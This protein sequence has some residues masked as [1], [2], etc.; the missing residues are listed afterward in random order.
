[1]RVEEF[2]RPKNDNRRGIHW[3][4]SV[5]HPAGSALDFWIS[6]LL[7][8]NVKWVKLLDDG[9][10]SSLDLCRR[11]LV[12][13][14]MPI[15]RLYRLEPNPGHIGGRE[16]ETVR[17]LIAE[18][19]RYFEANNE[20]DLP[21]EWKGGR[22]PPD[23]LETVI[24]NF[25]V[26]ADKIIGLGGLPAFPAM[27]V[28][29]TD[30]AME[31]VVQ[32]GRADLFSNG[33]WVALHNY[34]LNHPL[35]YP[36]DPVNQEGA[37]ATREEY[38]RLGPWAWE[39]RSLEQINA[40]RAA[41]KHPGATLQDD[42][43]CFLAFHLLDELIVKTLGHKVPIL[44]TEGG[45]V[46]GW[47]DDRRYPRID[48]Y[49]HAA[50]AVAINDFM[51]GGRAIHG[52]R[53]PDN[54]FTACHWLLANYRL[55]FMAPGW[56][57]NSWYSDWWN[58]DFHLKGE[59]PAVAAVKAMPNRPVDLA[60]Q[61]V[62][63]GRVLR[64]DND[65]SLPGLTVKL[66]AAGQEV[67]STGTASGGMFR[68]AKL[69]PGAYDLAIAPWGEVRQAVIAA[70]E[71]VQPVTIRLTGGRS[72]V[73]VGT[74]RN[75]AGIPLADAH[76]TLQRHGVLIGGTDTGEDGAFSFG[77]LPSGAYRL[78]APGI[79]VDGITLD[80]WQPKQLTLI[81]SEVDSRLGPAGGFAQ[82][83]GSMPGGRP[84]RVVR[85]TGAAGTRESKLA[86]D[87]SFA[88]PDLAAGRYSL[89][90]AGIGVI[91]DAIALEPGGQFKLIFPLQSRLAGQVQAAPDGLI[92][93]LYAP[94]SWGWTRQALLDLDGSFTFEGLPA[95]RYRL[96]IGELVLPSLDLTG[97]NRLQLAAIDL[98]QGRHSVVRGRVADGAGRPRGDILM[99]LSREGLIIAQARTGSDG[100]YG[101][102]DL[103]AG[104]YRLEATGMGVVADNIMLDG[105]REY[106][107]DVLW[108]GPGPRSILQGRVLSAGGAPVEGVLVRL[109][110]DDA[111]VSRLK[112][113][114]GGAF[115]FAGLAGGLY[116]LAVGEGGPL[117]SDIQVD[118]DA[119]VTRD[120]ILPVGP[121]KLL[122]H[123]LLF[124]VL[125]AP[126]T[127]PDAETRLVLLLA[128]DSL[129]HLAATG[130]FS[131]DEAVQAQRVT[132]LGDGVPASVE[133]RLRAAGCEVTRLA[134]DGFA[135]AGVLKRQLP[136]R[137][138][139]AGGEEVR[140]HEPV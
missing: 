70:P 28:G 106:V 124:G 69:P 102:A 120:A 65:E 87:G 110:K 22:L 60:Y 66:T 117:V 35:D 24:D 26:D 125:P 114:E 136:D 129:M 51:Q 79:T 121:D 105:Q 94:Q 3:S 93:V 103:P 44:S 101:F 131:A 61:A 13:D 15:V 6:E 76:V 113:A 56:E 137:E 80:G 14:I 123:Y 50:C 83:N 74:V 46:V 90:L 62:V 98:A 43:T 111:E 115:R 119:T 92:A 8:M 59:L 84:G 77:D 67:A 127:P 81:T 109:L 12:A 97:E 75:A 99:I 132:I 19:A 100:A 86:D 96:E 49:A 2:P 68:F 122:E 135:L 118:E 47:K 52:L 91:A 31:V 72:S 25:I 9:G 134:G 104:A 112:A 11:L 85:L 95:G 89:E 38:E 138:R 10:G 4:A 7:A 30:K 116:A 82:V 139:G 73:L 5:Y 78:V 18:G 16:E 58:P 140:S 29:A 126:G 36:Y 128:T 40:W 17:R 88:F 27:K 21:V 33:A 55:G 57:S 1:M 45:P 42:A 64:A 107:A 37:P 63:A 39:G 71:P 108:A 34:A 54:Y 48:P 130:G 41:D 23:W 53:C 32:R 20:P 133:G